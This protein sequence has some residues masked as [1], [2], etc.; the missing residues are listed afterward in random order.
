MVKLL[1]F[2]K[3]V[4][5]PVCAQEEF[6]LPQEVNAVGDMLAWLNQRGES[7]RNALADASSL[8]ITINKKIFDVADIVQAGDEI[9]FFPKGR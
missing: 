4:D 6:S 3:L 7:Y 9:A 1:Y 5:L 2:F 8:K